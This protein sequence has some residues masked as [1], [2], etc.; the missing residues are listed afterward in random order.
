VQS[1]TDPNELHPRLLA[2]LDQLAALVTTSSSMA[3]NDVETLCL[4]IA[5]TK[6]WFRLVPLRPSNAMHLF[7]W[8]GSMSD[9]FFQRVHCKCPIAL[10]ATAHRLTIIHNAPHPWFVFDWPSRAI[11][12][13][14]DA[15]EAAGTPWVMSWV[16]GELAKPE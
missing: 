15:V 13:I 3:V 6:L 8:L 5:Q 10:A 14:A 11:M 12:A 16:L 4:A 7:L 2:S 1:L 9:T